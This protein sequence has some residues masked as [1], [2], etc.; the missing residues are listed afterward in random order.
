MELN[1]I[2]LIQSLSDTQE[3]NSRGKLAEN[4][5]KE[6]STLPSYHYLLQSVY[7]DLTIPLQV[8]W[9]SI[10]QFK[11]GVDKHWRSVRNGGVISKEEKSQIMGRL[12]ELID[13]DNSQ[14]LI[15]NAHAT[16][17][18]C[19]FE[20]P[21]TWPN[22][23]SD[24]DSMLLEGFRNRNFVRIFNILTI[25]NQIIKALSQVKIGRTK[26]SMQMKTPL[27]TPL[28]IE[29][30]TTF[31]NE[32]INNTAKISEIDDTRIIDIDYLCLK[33]LRRIIVDGYMAPHKDELINDF[34][35]MNLKHFQKLLLEYKNLESSQSSNDSLIFGKLEKF[36]KCECKLYYNYIYSN[37]NSFLLIHNSTD[38]LML[39]LG[40][41]ESQASVIYNSSEEDDSEN[42]WATIAIKSL[43]IFKQLVMLN[44][45]GET[46]LLKSSIT[47]EDS[48]KANEKL[49]TFLTDNLIISLTELIINWYLKLRPAALENWN[50]N[51]EEFINEELLESWEY[52][53]RPCSENFFQTLITSYKELLVP[54][55]LNKITEI[56]GKIENAGQDLQLILL[57]DSI[58]AIIQLSGVAIAD[59]IDFDMFLTN[60]LIPSLNSSNSSVELKI[61]KRRACLIIDEWVSIKCSRENR[62][63]IYDLLWNI[64]Q[65]TDKVLQ[66]SVVKTLKIVIE[67][68]DFRKEDFKAYSSFFVEK[69]ITFLNEMDLIES[70]LFILNCLNSLLERNGSLI[71]LNQLNNLMEAYPSIWKYFEANY[72][73]S[74]MIKNI[75]IRILK[76]L[77]KCFKNSKLTSHISFEIIQSCCSYD[78]E[79]YNVLSEDG[80]ELWQSVMEY[81]PLENNENDPVLQDLIFNKFKLIYEPL[82]NT[83]EILPLILSIVRSYLIIMPI[84]IILSNHEMNELVKSVLAAAS[85]NIS[86]MRDDSL[87]LVLS[88]IDLLFVKTY[89]FYDSNELNNSKDIVK[90]FYELMVNS[91]I[92]EQLVMVIADQ[93]QN[94]I[95]TINKL[96]LIVS[97]FFFS[98]SK[99]VSDILWNVVGDVNILK[100]F[101]NSW[102]INTGNIFDARKKKQNLLGLSN[103]LLMTSNEFLRNLIYIKENIN[104]IFSI[105]ST[106]L[107]EINESSQGDCKAYYK[108]FNYYEFDLMYQNNQ[109]LREMDS[110]LDPIDTGIYE[111]EETMEFKR[112]HNVIVKND[113]VHIVCTKN[114]IK[115]ILN[116]LENE[117]GNEG[118]RQML[119]F[120]DEGFLENL[121]LKIQ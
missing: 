116:E 65:D 23:F 93:D 120:V 55:T 70:K 41:L 2:N 28:I 107:D 66:L 26:A 52:Q 46:I 84:Q 19:R 62:I 44:K 87:D 73:E 90:S 9:L 57:K 115:H 110:C 67:E 42:F 36:L 91:G 68:W 25:L 106:Y 100:Q 56:N 49:N 10:I 63:K 39:L 79:F 34:F 105:W 64:L 96:I 69:L 3:R 47:K 29:I 118:Y 104:L 45:K 22:L 101:F 20:F 119:E 51:P 11:N 32:W 74:L 60:T 97:R 92:F 58:F 71:E 88:I 54:F 13:E 21:N 99:I 81:Y 61:L 80:F 43:L 98:N 103:L 5:L 95:L 35:N 76:N 78:S 75:L 59:I 113:P 121:Q 15:Q 27:I 16:A 111:M 82:L 40:I 86:Y 112:Y 94:S 114:Y 30:Y 8:R 4:Q 37:S 24:I 7:L 33:V 109:E 108:C 6:W 17:K 18:V 53:I 102:L 12:F 89:E 50:D 85:K 72:S 48:Q 38:I 83:T 1:L 77:I 31:F 14:M 117:F